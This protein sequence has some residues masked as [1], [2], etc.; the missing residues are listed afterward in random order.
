MTNSE[1]VLAV[2]LSTAWLTT[3]VPSLA[4]QLDRLIDT[5][6]ASIS[7]AAHSIPAI[8]EESGQT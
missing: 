2:R 1:P 3:S 7:V 5:T 8:I 6:A 4:C